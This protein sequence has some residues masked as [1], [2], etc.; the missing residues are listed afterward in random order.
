MQL[1]FR[2][3]RK[4]E[5]KIRRKIF[6]AYV[7]PHVLWLLCIWF[8]FTHNQRDRIE[9]TFCSGLRILHNL[10]QW[11]DFTTLELA[12]EKSLRDHLYRYWRRFAHHLMHSDEG[13]AFQQ[14]WNSYLIITTPNSWMKTLYFRWTGVLPRSLI[15][16]ATHCLVEWLMFEK[17]HQMQYNYFRN[18]NEYMGDFVN[19]YFSKCTLDGMYDVSIIRR[20]DHGVSL[21]HF[22]YL[23]C[24]NICSLCSF[25]CQYVC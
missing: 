10:R 8:F 18:T 4:R 12:R 1:V 20:I 3:I 22:S 16:Q 19:K 13:L 6:F 5:I 2:T 11:D 21:S 23:I 15:Q 17:V 24:L 25:Y 14:S 9:H 7:L